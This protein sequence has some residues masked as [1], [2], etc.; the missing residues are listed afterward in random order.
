MKTLANCT[1]REF[2][3]Q[4]NKIR[5]SVSRWLKLTDIVNIRKRVPALP[6]DMSKED[7]D[8]AMREQA[9]ENLNAMLDAMLDEHPDETIEVLGLLCFIEPEDLDNYKMS[10]LLGGFAEVIGCPEVINFFISLARLGNLNTST[11]AGR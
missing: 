10:D 8:K 4:T 2:L 1:P 11:I 7:R 9:T 6:L 5:K 3:V